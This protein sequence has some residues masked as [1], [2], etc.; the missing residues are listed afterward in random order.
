MRSDA[1]SD[2][3]SGSVSANDA[4]TSPDASFGSHAAFCSG[5]PASTRPCEPMPTLLPNADRNAGDVRPSSSTASVSSSIVRPS[6][7]YSS[8]IDSPKSPS[9]RISRTTGSGI[10]SA[11]LT[12]RSRG[13]SR[14]ATKRRS[15]SR[16]AAKVSGSRIIG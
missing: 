5:V 12:S 15:V 3:A 13:T 11:S 8:A 16:K 6:P 7:P 2:P 4:T 1:A 10:A 9:V 14:S